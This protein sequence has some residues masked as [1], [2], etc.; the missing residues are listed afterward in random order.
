M[1]WS[2]VDAVL[3]DLDGVLTPTA[4]IHERAWKEMFDA[5]LG[6]RAAAS[7]E[8]PVPFSA[9]DYLTYVDGKK[10]ADGVRSFVRSRGI[11][12]P[13]GEATDAP[14]DGTIHALGNAKNDAF[15]RVLR[16]EGIAPYPG[17]VRFLD[18]LA[19]RGTAAAVVSSSRNAPEV[20]A[21][22]GLASR[23]AVVVDGSVAGAEGLA[24]KPAPDMFLAAAAKLGVAAA[25]AVVV[26]DALSGVAAGRAGAFAAVIGVDRGAGREAL[27]AGG[28]DVV[29]TDLADLLPLPALDGEPR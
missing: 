14:G 23:F 8:E 27:V 7:G 29:V 18:A 19:E 15:Q 3:L 25:R 6:R 13:E 10:R 26:E 11:D 28:A 22:A 1:H 2:A 12:L 20:L 9:D 24:G 17:S 4:A 21:A 5:F 16:T